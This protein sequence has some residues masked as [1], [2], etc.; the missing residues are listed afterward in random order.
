MQFAIGEFYE[1]HS[2]LLQAFKAKCSAT[3]R[4]TQV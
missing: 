4:S 3:A 1:C 2:S